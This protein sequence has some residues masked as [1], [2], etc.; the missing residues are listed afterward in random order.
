MRVA[1][2]GGLYEYE[3]TPTHGFET[4]SPAN[5]PGPSLLDQVPR[6]ISTQTTSC[7]ARILRNDFLRDAELRELL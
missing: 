6:T 2:G 5:P 3:P 7:P 4:E 1:R